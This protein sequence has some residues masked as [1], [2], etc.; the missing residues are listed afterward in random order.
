MKVKL[1]KARGIAGEALDV[2]S[3]VEVSDRDG[4]RLVAA[5]R[6]EKTEAALKKIK[7]KAKSVAPASNS[8]CAKEL[9]KVQSSLADSEKS[10]ADLTEQLE[11]ANAQIKDLSEQLEAVNPAE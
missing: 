7:L 5:K 4:K 9:K 10:V 3:V 11:A 8:E 6:A 2:N 1:L